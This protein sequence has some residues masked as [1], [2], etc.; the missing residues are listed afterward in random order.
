MIRGRDFK[1]RVELFRVAEVEDAYGYIS[2]SFV[3]MGVVPAAVRTLTGNRALQYQEMGIS[4]P[5]ALEIR[6]VSFPIAKI[7]YNGYEIIPRSV[8]PSDEV[9]DFSNRD[10]GKFLIIEGSFPVLVTT[11]STTTTTTTTTLV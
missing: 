8:L 6:T 1:E 2:S 11:T 3:S 9:D 7:K 10:R 5:V 4:H